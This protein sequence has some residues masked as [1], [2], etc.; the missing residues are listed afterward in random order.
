MKATRIFSEKQVFESIVDPSLR[1]FVKVELFKIP[2]PEAQKYPEGIKF[3]LLAFRSDDPNQKILIDCHPPK[4]PHIHVREIEK[5]F[6]WIDL[7]KTYALFWELIEKEF[8]K[9]KEVKE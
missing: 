4:G 5:S 8:G 2:E 1:V 6:E 3:S 7:D 9:L